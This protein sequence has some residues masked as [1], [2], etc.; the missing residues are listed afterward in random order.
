MRRIA[1]GRQ[2]QKGVSQL[3]AVHLQRAVVEIVLQDGRHIV[4]EIAERL[5]Q[6]GY[7]RITRRVFELRPGDGGVIGNITH[8]GELAHNLQHPLTGSAKTTL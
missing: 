4:M 8:P 2:K 1:L 3:H 6:P 7:R 5:H